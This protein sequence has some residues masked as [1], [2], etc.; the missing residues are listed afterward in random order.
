VSVVIRKKMHIFKPY[1]TFANM[2]YTT[3]TQS[4]HTV[5]V[6]YIH[7][8]WKWTVASSMPD[9]YTLMLPCRCIDFQSFFNMFHL[10]A[11][12]GKLGL[13]RSIRLEN[14]TLGHFLT[15]NALDKL[16]DP[17]LIQFVKHLQARAQV[18]CSAYAY[19]CRFTKSQCLTHITYIESVCYAAY[20]AS[21]ACA[22][23]HYH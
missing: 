19:Y 8:Y 4:T 23:F 13:E 20:S 17:T 2:C 18:S 5:H 1:H 21:Y 12:Q 3:I 10:T 14:L 6:I 9:H 11:H 15:Q 16:V 22:A 7:C